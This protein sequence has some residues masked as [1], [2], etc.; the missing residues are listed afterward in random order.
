MDFDAG[1]NIADVSSTIRLDNAHNVYVGGAT[2]N[3]TGSRGLLIKYSQGN[4]LTPINN[5]RKQITDKDGTNPLQAY[6]N[7]VQNQL[8]INNLN[9]YKLGTI[10]IYN[11]SGAL[12]YQGYFIPSLTTINLKNLSAGAYWITSDQSSKAIKF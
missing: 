3:S 10:N 8:T 1:T 11:A 7:P 4:L 6:P 9:N 5:I 12:I 2:G